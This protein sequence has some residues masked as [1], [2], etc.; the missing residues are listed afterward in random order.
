MN[1][2]K[3]LIGGA[4]CLLSIGL[5]ATGYWFLSAFAGF[6]GAFLLPDDITKLGGAVLTLAGIWVI[7]IHSSPLGAVFIL[8]GLF[9][10]GAGNGGTSAGGR[11]DTGGFG[12][13]FGGGSDGGG[14]GGDGGGGGGGDGGGGGC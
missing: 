6:I 10:L 13:S 2:L 1:V 14:Y 7:A 8:L 4:L 12:I 5:F 9:S 3:G 11:H